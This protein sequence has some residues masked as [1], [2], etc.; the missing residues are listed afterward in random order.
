MPNSITHPDNA[1]AFVHRPPTET[2]FAKFRLLLSTFQDGTGMLATSNG[3][4]LPG[5]R[6]FERATALAFGGVS[7]ENKD[8]MD[9]RLPDPTHENT[10]FG[11]SCKMRRELDRT[12]RAGRVT[13][14]LSNAARAFWDRLGNYAITPDNYRDNASQVGS[15]IIDLVRDW[16]LSASIENGGDIDLEGSC[17]LTLMWNNR[18][19]YQLSQFGIHLPDP[20]ELHWYCPEVTRR[21]VSTTGNRICADDDN[22]TVFEWYGQSGGQL[23]YYPLINGAIWSSDVFRLEPLPL[24]TPHG[25]V[26]KAQDYYPDLW[27][28]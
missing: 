8:I 26:S 19:Q 23:K 24:D 1:I 14:E 9:V 16:H 2:E 12:R 7:S 18:G 3:S 20:T 27:P 28:E 10:F 17:Y 21:G 25:L 4:T 11:I 22:G 15:A 6:D 5:W 13:I